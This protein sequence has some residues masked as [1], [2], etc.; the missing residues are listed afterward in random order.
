MNATIIFT[1][2]QSAQRPRKQ[3]ASAATVCEED[4][5]SNLTSAFQTPHLPPESLW[6]PPA[7]LS[8]AAAL[9]LAP[10]PPRTCPDLYNGQIKDSHRLILGF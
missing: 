10:C 9:L 3:T 7:C 2:P 6:S 1:K 4:S 8:A 5:F